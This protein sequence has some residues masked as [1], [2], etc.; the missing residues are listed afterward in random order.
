MKLFSIRG[1]KPPEYRKE[2][3]SEK[4][5]V[6]MPMPSALYI[7]LQQHIGAPAEVLVAEGDLVR[8][9]QMIA[10]NQG[11]VSASQHAPPAGRITAVAEGAAPHPSG[12]AQKNIIL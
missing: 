2:L 6:A 11:T 5:I 3:T 12:F 10:R 9:G 8:K 7:P 4:A 1:G